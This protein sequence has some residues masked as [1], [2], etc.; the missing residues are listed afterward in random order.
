MGLITEVCRVLILIASLLHIFMAGVFFE[1]NRN[2]D[3]LLSL[4]QG[5]GWIVF[6]YIHWIVF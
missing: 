3:G 6:V 2:G 4:F 5:I 1:K